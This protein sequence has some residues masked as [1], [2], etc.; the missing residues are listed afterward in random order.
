MI[1]KPQLNDIKNIGYYLGRIILGI[2]L[3]MFLPLIA[4]FVLFREPN[5]ALDLL[6][7]L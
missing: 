4:G 2:G 7:W 1:L 5:P 6:A 3:T